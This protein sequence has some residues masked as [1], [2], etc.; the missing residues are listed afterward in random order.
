MT[1]VAY[2]LGTLASDM[3]IQTDNQIDT[4][5]KIHKSPD[6]SMVM[7]GAGT[8]VEILK[9]FD[10][11]IKMPDKS[12]FEVET[13]VDMLVS[14]IAKDSVATVLMI[15]PAFKRAYVFEDFI[16]SHIDK[17]YHA[18]GTGSQFALATMSLGFGAKKAIQVASKFDTGTGSDVIQYIGWRN[19]KG[20]K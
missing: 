15:Y 9:I 17:D 16:W 4:W 11:L 18:I 8:Y 6:N 14:G 12:L 20:K 10:A 13:Y 1:T 3:Q 7:A 5:Y 2:R 19:Y